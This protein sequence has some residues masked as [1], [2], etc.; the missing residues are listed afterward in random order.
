MGLSTTHLLLLLLVIVLLF[1][2]G[3]IAD[4][5]GD[6]GRGIKSFKNAMNEETPAVKPADPKV[7]DQPGQ[8]DRDRT[9]TS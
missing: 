7:I 8:T 9:T 3:K 1:G 4:L 2:R 5:M 6:F